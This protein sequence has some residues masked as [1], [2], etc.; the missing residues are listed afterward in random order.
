[1]RIKGIS[2]GGP[3]P[4]VTFQKSY[5]KVQSSNFSEFV[6]ELQQLLSSSQQSGGGERTDPGRPEQGEAMSNA[7]SPH[8]EFLYAL[9]R[10]PC[11]ACPLRSAF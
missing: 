7:G 2:L 6:A 9:F 5:F 4:G 11:A 3:S 10:S 8:P 1:M